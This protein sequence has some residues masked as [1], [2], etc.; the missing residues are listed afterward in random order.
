[1]LA[2]TTAIR[3]V[4]K[5]GQSGELKLRF[6][7]SC[8]RTVVSRH[9]A[10]APFGAAWANYPDDSGM[11]E[12]Q[13]TNPA[14]GI[15]G[16]DRLRIEVS[17]EPG[18][19]VAILTQ[20]ASKAY[21]GEKA[22]QRV[23]FQV[24]RN[25]FLEYLPHHLIPFAASNYR[26]DTMFYL[27]EGAAL[28]TWDA[29]SAGRVAHGEHFAFGRL[30]SSTRIFLQEAPV[31]IDGFDFTGGGK[32][33]GEYFYLAT[34]YVLSPENAGPLAE[35][36]QAY[37]TKSPGVFASASAPEPHLCVARILSREAPALYQ[38]LNGCRL[39]A[40]RYLRLSPPARDVL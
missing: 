38:A 23:I 16:G 27:E 5:S 2:R 18:S 4:I 8:G 31:A 14:G 26:Q 32:P 1:M 20:A 35:K 30:S 6:A 29:Y 22:S 25:A 15:L 19:S 28:I 11:P 24:G 34:V 37:L 10:K 17:L 40:R 39:F 21:R 7:L 13:I 9:Y 3:T 36:L 33:F 12:V